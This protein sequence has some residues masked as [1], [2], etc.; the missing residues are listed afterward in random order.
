MPFSQEDQLKYKALYLQTARQ[1][2]KDLTDN[3]ALLSSG[4]E[5]QEVIDTLHRDA[6]SLKGQ[7]EMMGYHAVGALSRLMENIFN[8]KKEN[9]LVLT[10]VIITQLSD[11]VKE[12]AV[13]LD[14]IDKVNKELDMYQTIEKLKTSTKIED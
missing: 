11:G 7:S 1:Y 3:L 4:K 13:C 12:I 8:A 14:E 6:H 2:V 9:K 10:E 5:T